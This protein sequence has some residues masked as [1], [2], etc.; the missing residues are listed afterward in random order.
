MSLR[1]KYI[2]YL[3]VLFS[4]LWHCNP[5]RVMAT[6]FLRFLDHTQRRTTVGRTPL[7][8][9]SARRRDPL[10]DNRQHWQETNIHAP[11]G[12]R[13]RSSSKQ[14]AADTRIR[15]RRHW[16][17]PCCPIMVKIITKLN[18]YDFLFSTTAHSGPW[19]PYSR[20]FEITHNDAPQSVGLLWTSDQLVTE[21]YT[22]QHTTITTD[23]LPCPRWDSNPRSQQA[24]G[25]RPTP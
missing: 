3:V 25:R 11:G 21:T 7:D 23:K 10:S 14:A 19:P 12:I 17:R 8:E 24:S 5:T 9:R 15:P 13:T 18:D 6:S 4:F 1:Y 22:W 20:G 16:D 2:A